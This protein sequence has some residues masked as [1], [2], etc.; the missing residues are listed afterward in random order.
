MVPIEPAL[1]IEIDGLRRATGSLRI[2]RI[3]PHITLVPPVNVPEDRLGEALAVVRGVASTHRPISARLGPPATF[4][5]R[6]P[7]VFLAVGGEEVAAGALR[8]LRDDV[9]VP[10]IERRSDH[11]FHP[12][13]T[14]NQRADPERIPA[15]VLGL[16]E[17]EVTTVLDRV[18][19]L[20]E[21]R[22]GDHERGWVAIADYPLAPPRIVGRG[23]IELA[24]TVCAVA[25]AEAVALEAG[26]A[27]ELAEEA[28]AAGERA[29][30][31][32]SAARFV[33]RGAEPLVIHARTRH[34]GDDDVLVGVGRGWVRHGDHEVTSV[35]V[36][37][38][39]RSEGIARQ[40]RL[41]LDAELARRADA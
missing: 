29:P 31:E 24:L 38:D 11:E 4:A 30:F 18:Q 27:H 21:T 26:V 3:E 41:T 39:R 10:P 5:P 33:P 35:V 28:E 14:L 32:L 40:L 7:V 1:S 37:P 34:D 23:G 2:G 16:R 12:H 25:D 22:H 36:H 9:N 13:V 20:E 19:V 8:R 6:N 15:M 17:Y